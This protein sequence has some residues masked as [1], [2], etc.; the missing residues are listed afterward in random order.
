LHASHSPQ[1]VFLNRPPARRPLCFLGRA[2][3]DAESRLDAAAFAIIA[4]HYSPPPVDYN[5]GEQA[6]AAS[7]AGSAAVTR[8]EKPT[9]DDILRE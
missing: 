2:P 8:Q 6:V 4:F 3:S 7:A 9:A 5:A 1:E